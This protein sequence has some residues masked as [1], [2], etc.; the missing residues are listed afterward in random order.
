MMSHA[1]ALPTHVLMPS[2]ACRKRSTVM[3]WLY[4]LPPPAKLGR[5]P[6]AGGVMNQARRA[7]HDPSARCAGTSPRKAWGGQDCS[8]AFTLQLHRLGVSAPV[9]VERHLAAHHRVL[10]P[11][12]GA[13]GEGELRFD[14]LLEQRVLG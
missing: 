8:S 3:G 12:R 2:I 5:W 1:A 13:L 9:V 14:D 11:L 4:S 10:F 7:A 6:Q